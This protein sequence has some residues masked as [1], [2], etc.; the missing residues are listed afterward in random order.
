M[1]EALGYQSLDEMISKGYGLE[2]EEV[3]IARR[4]L[5][6]NE[7]E[8]AVGLG[9]VLGRAEQTMRKARENGEAARP[10]GRQPKGMNS[11]NSNL[12]PSGST[13][14][15]TRIKRL[16]RDHPDVAARLDAGELRSVA[17]AEAHY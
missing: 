13:A 16:R 15:T 11:E 3:H 5:E 12:Q 8:S 10:R 17:A 7:P 4:W 9:E 6:I 1:W 2:P 14:A